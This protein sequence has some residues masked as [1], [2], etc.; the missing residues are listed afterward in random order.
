MNNELKTITAINE[1]TPRGQIT[2][3]AVLEYDRPLDRN[4]DK[5]TFQ[6]NG[7]I[8]G[9][10]VS[11]N[12]I[13]FDLSL[14]EKNKYTRKMKGFG[15]NTRTKVTGPNLKIRQK[16]KIHDIQGNAINGWLFPR[17]AD[18]QV[19]PVV[20]DF[21]QDSFDYQGKKLS[22]NLFIPKET[23]EKMVVFL[24][25]SSVCSND[26]KA[27]LLQGM[28]A[29][30]FA[31]EHEERPC[32]V[33]APLFEEKCAND[34]FE[35]T[36]HV[37]ALAQLIDYL[38]EKYDLKTV[39]GTGQ[40]MGTM[41]LCDM[42]VRYPGLYDACYLVAGQ[43]D[44]EKMGNVDTDLWIMV[45]EKDEKA[46]PIMMKAIDNMQKNGIGVSIDHIDAKADEEEIESFVNKLVKDGKR[47]IFTYYE[48]S[49]VLPEGMKEFPGCFHLCTW[50]YAYGIKG[51][52]EW[53][54]SHR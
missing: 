22:Y 4:I 33:L 50:S 6:V 32:Y 21:I 51:I 29:I 26:V 44:P 46:Y 23:T 16:K 11:D 27:P 24:H 43:W 14:N 5:D 19:S 25:D 45:S 20:D 53:L 8:D 3:K 47:V 48:G 1:N 7:T 12:K 36:W 49:S 41:M 18:S 35:T 34:D 52:R 54:F 40:S 28:G 9:L 37:D 30:V 39:Y 10:I 15:P 17:K 38:K 2:S 13:L 42:L 31:E